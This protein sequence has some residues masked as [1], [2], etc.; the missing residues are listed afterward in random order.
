VQPVVAHV[1]DV[2]ELTAGLDLP[3]DLQLGVIELHE[4]GRVVV[5]RIAD[6]SSVA[7]VEF[8]QVRQIPTRECGSHVRAT[9]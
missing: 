2:L 8:V 3:G 9:A 5:G 4:I 6:H 1:E 7:H